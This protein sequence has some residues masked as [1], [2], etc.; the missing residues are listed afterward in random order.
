MP[1]GETIAFAYSR[2]AM[3]RL[4]MIAVLLTLLSI[5]AAF[6][7]IPNMR[8][9]PF[10]EL[11]GFLGLFVFGGMIPIFLARLLQ[12]GPIVVVGGRGIRDR[13][14]S[15]DVM[16]WDNIERLRVTKGRRQTFLQLQLR[17]PSQLRRTI[18][19]RIV[20]G[21]VSHVSIN[22]TGLNG[23][24]DDLVSAVGQYRKVDVTS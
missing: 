9:R 12:A 16:T 6:Q 2:P 14:V 20:S 5:V 24:F 1:D 23:S 18:L 13:R 19:N 3:L 7:L 22:M 4:V 17:A 15:D 8:H 10:L 11:G 21:G